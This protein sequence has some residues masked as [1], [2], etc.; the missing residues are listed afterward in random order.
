MTATKTVRLRAVA[1]ALAWYGSATVEQLARELDLPLDDRPALT[2]ALEFWVGRGEARVQT[3]LSRGARGCAGG[4]CGAGHRAAG[5]AP[6]APAP[7][8]V[9]TWTGKRP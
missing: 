6:G 2:M 9:F 7:T 1:D 3:R 8:Q 5:T 4:C